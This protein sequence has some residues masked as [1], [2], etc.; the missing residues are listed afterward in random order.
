MVVCLLASYG[1]AAR[2]LN[3]RPTNHSTNSRYATACHSCRSS[4][5]LQRL[6][7]KVSRYGYIAFPTGKLIVSVNR[8]ACRSSPLVPFI[9]V[10]RSSCLQ[11]NLRAIS[12]R[13]RTCP[14]ASAGQ[15]NLRRTHIVIIRSR[16]HSGPSLEVYSISS[17]SISAISCSITRR[18]NLN[19]VTR[20]TNQSLCRSETQR[21]C[22][23]S[24]MLASIQ[25]VLISACIRYCV[26]CNRC[27]LCTRYTYLYILRS[28]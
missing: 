3:C 11:I 14:S 22:C 12:S 28:V 7:A 25:R 16:R 26:P 21:T 2:V 15:T 4:Q 1:I 9:T 5:F 17:R 6:R 20:C 8:T 19:S 13:N 23:R 18:T 27:R 10:T 24:P